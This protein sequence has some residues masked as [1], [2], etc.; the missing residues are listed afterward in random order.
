[1]PPMNTM[2]YTEFSELCHVSLEMLMSEENLSNL[3]TDQNR[4]SLQRM[5]GFFETT[6]DYEACQDLQDIALEIFGERINPIHIKV[7]YEDQ[8]KA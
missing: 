4:F 2:T 8:S 7:I 6:E 3:K 5:L 1:M